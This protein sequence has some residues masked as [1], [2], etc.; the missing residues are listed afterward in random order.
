MHQITHVDDDVDVDVTDD[1]SSVGSDIRVDVETCLPNQYVNMLRQLHSTTQ[2]PVVKHV[3]QDKATSNKHV[4]VKEFP[5]KNAIHDTP[6]SNPNE[7]QE[8][9]LRHNIQERKRRRDLTSLFKML[10]DEL[11]NNNGDF[12]WSFGNVQVYIE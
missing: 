12:Q 6:N 9:L 7:V 10:R 8:R 11:V 3:D 1:T 5:L 2:S 4:A